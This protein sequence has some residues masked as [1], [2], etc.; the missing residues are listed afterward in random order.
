[1]KIKKRHIAYSCLGVTLVLLVVKKRKGAV[2]E[3]SLLPAFRNWFGGHERLTNNTPRGI[4][5]NNAGNLVQTSIAWKGKLD[6]ANNTDSRFEQFISPEYG[7][8]ALIKDV[9]NDINKGKNTVTKVIHEFA[10]VWENNTKA[11]IAS[12]ARS[13]NITPNQPLKADYNTLLQLVM[14]IDKHENGK[15]YIDQA[16]F[17]RAWSLI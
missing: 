3:V 11:Y 1:M 5:N 16:L 17:A 2:R 14:A 10:P 4:R 6:K 8:R 13:M 15:N 7:V 9:M 12:V